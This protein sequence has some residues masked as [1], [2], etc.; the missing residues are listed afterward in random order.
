MA[1]EGREG[2]N[3]LTSDSLTIEASD[4]SEFIIAVFRLAVDMKNDIERGIY[5]RF[6]GRGL[7][8]TFDEEELA[9][10]TH[11][12]HLSPM[13]AFEAVVEPMPPLH[14]LIRGG[15]SRVFW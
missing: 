3:I 5:N 12:A 8:H 14:Y 2:F 11:I 7:D 15:Q 13:E 6:L 10:L 9:L 4:I 1:A